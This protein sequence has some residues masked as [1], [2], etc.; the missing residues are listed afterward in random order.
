MTMSIPSSKDPSVYTS[1]V[2][3]S[4]V[5]LAPAGLVA[6]DLGMGELMIWLTTTMRQTDADIRGQ[7]EQINAKKNLNEKLGEVITALRD[8]EGN[9]TSDG[10]AD[11]SRMGDLIGSNYKEQEWYKSLPTS[12]QN[13]FDSF[14]TNSKVGGDG[15]LGD[16]KATLESTKAAREALADVV[17]ANSSSNEMAMIKLQ[18]A[19]SARGQAIQLIS[20]MVNAFNETSKSVVG[21]I[22]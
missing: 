4:G 20:N 5:S 3:T 1:K 8:A 15:P 11:T 10:F 2:E 12:A 21:N 17:S 14:V 19:I 7:M 13:A 6:G 18:S 22:R 9:K 16:Q